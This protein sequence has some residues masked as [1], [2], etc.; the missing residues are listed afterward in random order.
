M[1]ETFQW[2]K[3]L[4]GLYKV[5]NYGRVKSYLRKRTQL[6][7]PIKMANGIDKYPLRINGQRKIFT[8]DELY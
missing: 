6:I 5:S 8:L 4:E 7:K 3:G 1:E 2:I